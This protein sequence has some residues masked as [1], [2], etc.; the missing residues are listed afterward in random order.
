[1][2]VSQ[3]RMMTILNKGSGGDRTSRWCDTFL[4]VL[5]ILN[6]VAVCLESV[7]SFNSLYHAELMLFET[8]S[9]CIFLLE[10]GLRIWSVAA[11]EESSATTASGRRYQYIFSFTGIIDLLAILP[12]ILPLVMGGVD[13]RWLRVLRLV[14]LLKISHY[15]SALEDLF[16]AVYQ[17]RR[18]FFAALYLLGIALFLSS[19]LMYLAEYDAQPEKFASIPQTMWWALITLTTIGYGDV[20]PV[21]PLGQT[22]GAFTALMG[23]CTVALLTGIVASA[24]SNQ[25]ARREAIFEAEITSALSD[26]LVTDD[27]QQNIEELREKFK[28]TEEHARAI[29][30][31]IE[32]KRGR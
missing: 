19:S 15:S 8:V 22:I 16:S 24:F 26:G 11:D 9:V 28:I 12:S 1:M 6:L 23:I 7:S 17:E 14:R 31:L 25:M 20:Y 2:F 32:E 21:T 5:I 27:E 18:S 4:S 10:Y 3:Q 29:F 13:L 30:A